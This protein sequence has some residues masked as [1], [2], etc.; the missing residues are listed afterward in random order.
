MVG[1]RLPGNTTYDPPVYGVLIEIDLRKESD[2]DQE[3]GTLERS[4]LERAFDAVGI[5]AQIIVYPT[6]S[7]VPRT[8]ITLHVGYKPRP[9]K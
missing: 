6:I 5:P 4:V 1:R 7:T 3:T 2:A 8:F 9:P